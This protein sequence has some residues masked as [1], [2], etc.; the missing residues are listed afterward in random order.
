MIRWENVP[1]VYVAAWT[2]YFLFWRQVTPMLF[3]E[4]DDGR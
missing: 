2:T 1:K 4:F 3:K